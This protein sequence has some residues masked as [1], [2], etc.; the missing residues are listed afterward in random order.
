MNRLQE[1]LHAI[2]DP[3]VTMLLLRQEFVQQALLAAALLGVISGLIGPFIVMRNMAF[4]VHGTSE[5]AFTGAAAALL[6]GFAV[7][8]GAII[9]SVLVAV[10]FGVMGR[11]ADE[12]DSVIG[13][14]MAFGLGLGV[15]FAHLYPGRS[16]TAFSLLTGQIVSAGAEGATLMAGVTAV[17]VATMALIYR[18]LLFA[19]TDPVVAAAR[20]VPTRLISVVFAVIVGLV[21]AQGVQVVGALLVMSLLITP[22]AAAARVTSSPGIAVLLSVLFAEIAAVGGIVLA[23][24]PGV[25]ISVFVTTISFAIYLLCRL[26]AT[27]RGRRRHRA[28]AH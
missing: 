2:G 11:R 26:W 18:P 8:P 21:A 23:L 25:P 4:S 16:G 7:G 12:R 9:G 1:I 6:F 28:A 17:V 5:L 13:V 3:E 22:G 24:A 10:L 15:L 19:S 20:G 27:L 14:I